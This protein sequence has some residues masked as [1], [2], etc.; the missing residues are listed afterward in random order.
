MRNIAWSLVV[1]STV[2]ADDLDTRVANLENQ[3]KQLRFETPM[4]N[5]GANVASSLP[6][7]NATGFYAS[8]DLLRWT[9]Y[10]GGTDWAITDLSNGN[11]APTFAHVKDL[12][13]DWEWGYRAAIGYRFHRDTWDTVVNY[14]HFDTDHKKR[15]QNNDASTVLRS[16]ILSNGSVDF[17]DI[18]IRWRVEFSQLN[19]ELGRAY[20]VSRTFSLRPH[21]GLT[22]AWI[23][24]SYH[25]HGFQASAQRTDS[26]KAKNDFC[27]IGVRAGVQP[28]WFISEHF[29][30][31]GSLA[32]A[33]LYGKFD[34]KAKYSVLGGG[35]NP[36][37][38]LLDQDQDRH[39]LAPTL[40]TFLGLGWESNFWKD[41]C[42]IALTA[43]YEL[44][45]WWKQNQTPS[46]NINGPFGWSRSSEDL[47]L[48]G[49]TGNFRFDF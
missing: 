43:G 44:Q 25:T 30:V 26:F 36:Q 31:Q 47:A 17:D 28:K 39:A 32:G 8:A 7:I 34:V 10:E 27:G 41:H 29:N 45:Y 18:P 21:V 14:T 6:Q 15:V 9:V 12:E 19:W 5:H 38:T 24:Q 35:I 4:G 46:F 49:F 40:D 11:V 37:G 42:H 16:N 3:M 1:F 23:D 20:F 48:H 22:G 2:L 33:I 13:F